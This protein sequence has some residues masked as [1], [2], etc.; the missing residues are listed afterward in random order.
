MYIIYV[1][2]IKHN[3]D[4]IVLLLAV[5][6]QEKLEKIVDNANI[7]NRQRTIPGGEQS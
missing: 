3:Y 2:R 5:I 4:S 7:E 1:K 6:L